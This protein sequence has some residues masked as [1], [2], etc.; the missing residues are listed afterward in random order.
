MT[1]KAAAEAASKVAGVS[2]VLVA[3]SDALRRGIAE[4]YAGLVVGLQA[5][6]GA[7]RRASGRVS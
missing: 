6:H 4:P 2:K 3:D 1:D 7:W 5:K